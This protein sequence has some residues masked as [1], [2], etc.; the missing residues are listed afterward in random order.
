MSQETITVTHI[1]VPLDGSPQAEH[2][3]PWAADLARRYSAQLVLFR[4]GHRPEMWSAQDVPSIDLFFEKEEGQCTAYLA[5]AKA[6]LADAGLNIR[7]EYSLGSP[8]QCI[9]DMSAELHGSMIVMT[10]HGR[11]GLTRW[12][13]GS[14]AEKV[15]RH[16]DC[17]V[18]LIRQPK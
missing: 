9:L 10:S 18:V 8:A 15:A 17:P 2:A 11:D 14:V 6:K 3:I 1:L 13:M 5:E 16:A 7:T 12:V 4:V